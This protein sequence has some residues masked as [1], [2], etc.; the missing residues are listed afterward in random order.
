MSWT[1]DIAGTD[2]SDSV[3]DNITVYWG[4]E[5]LYRQP[6]PATCTISIV[7]V[8]SDI[9]IDPQLFDIDQPVTVYTNID[10]T[11]HYR[12][13]GYIT[14]I[15]V[16]FYTIDLVAVSPAARL[17][18]YAPYVDLTPAFD[19]GPIWDFSQ[20]PTGYKLE[21]LIPDFPG[22]PQI[23]AD[24]GE[25]SVG[26]W[27]DQPGIVNYWNAVQAIV[28]GEQFGVLVDDMTLGGAPWWQMRFTDATAR[29]QTNPTL[30][31]TGNEIIRDWT[32][33]KQVGDKVNYLTVSLPAHPD[34]W[35]PENNTNF[36]QP[37]DSTDIQYTG[38]LNPT[39]SNPETV[40]TL[41]SGIIGLWRTPT[42]RLRRISIP[43]S[44]LDETRQAAI[45]TNVRMSE[46]VRLPEIVPG[47][48]TDYFIEGCQD[49]FVEG[50]Y[51]LTLFLSDATLS[52]P[53]DR[54]E[55]ADP[56]LEWGQVSASLT[57]GD[58]YKERFN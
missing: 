7:R 25:S 40:A 34:G 28:A 29:R 51:V 32:L 49:Q 24:T 46:L 36:D 52:H 31:F 44:A 8:T 58:A 16:N 18:S 20:Y 17:A 9:T 21:T 30:T 42:Y 56:T 45:L 26:F 38:D 14:D 10:A 6:N 54:W 55:D 37:S 57:W 5:D 1:V 3:I 47:L 15:T 48:P 39:Y 35:W 4:R 50:R 2:Y 23:T 41:A 19:P 33:T 53:P 27:Y 12:F 11:D 13:Y 22:N 43:M